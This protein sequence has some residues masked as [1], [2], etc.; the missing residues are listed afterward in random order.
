MVTVTV[1]SVLLFK[2]VFPNQEE[3]CSLKEVTIVD[4]FWELKRKETEKRDWIQ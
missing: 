2:P 3:V 1:K 4:F